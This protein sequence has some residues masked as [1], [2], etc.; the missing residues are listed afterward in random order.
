MLSSAHLCVA[1]LPGASHLGYTA[2]VVALQV[3]PGLCREVVGCPALVRVALVILHD[4]L[5]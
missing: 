3:V 1:P 4:V 2:Q 5:S